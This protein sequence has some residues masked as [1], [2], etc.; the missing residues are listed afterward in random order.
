M[1]DL[2]AGR[3]VPVMG[4]REDWLRTARLTSGLI[5]MSFVTLHLIN[6]TL[7]LI[8]IETA[9]A[10][11]DVFMAPWRNPVGS[12]VLLASVLVHVWLALLA[13]YRRRSLV[14][15]VKE[16]A[17]LLLGLAIPI[18]IAEHVMGTKLYSELSG[19][20]ASYAMVANSLWVQMPWSAV[21]QAIAVLVIWGHG[22]MGVY[23]WLR[24]RPWFVSVAPFMLVVAALLPVLALLG[25]V[26]A[27]R[28]VET[29]SFTGDDGIAPAVLDA[30]MAAKNRATGVVYAVYGATL[31]LVWSCVWGERAASVA[32]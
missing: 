28:A 9:E 14:M 5:L 30:A 18:L 24:Y 25:F 2:A 22:C 31:V 21:K 23:F 10:A 13:L 7:A 11:S 20:D 3:L 29:A 8:S 4:R 12:L 32:T 19:V 15:P 1:S 16:A 17:Q 6:H 26:N 27:G